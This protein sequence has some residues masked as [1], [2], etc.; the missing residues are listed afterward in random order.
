MVNED[1]NQILTADGSLIDFLLNMIKLALDDKDRRYSG[2]SAHELIDGLAKLAKNDT[3][4]LKIMDKKD[5]FPMLKKSVLQKK[6]QEEMLAA[7]SVVWELAFVERNK[8]IFAV[9]L[10]ILYYHMVV[11]VRSNNQR[12][13]ISYNDLFAKL[14]FTEKLKTNVLAMNS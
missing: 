1:Q 8:K 7:V 4:K 6:S 9:S 10:H 2:F 3:N 11:L 14:S 12:S 13:S 5:T